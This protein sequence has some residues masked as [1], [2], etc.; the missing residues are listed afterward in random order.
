MSNHPQPKTVTSGFCWGPK[1]SNEHWKKLIHQKFMKHHINY[2]GPHPHLMIGV[3]HYLRLHGRVGALNGLPKANHIVR[4]ASQFRDFLYIPTWT[5]QRVP[6]GSWVSNHHPLGSNWH[7][8]ER[9]GILLPKRMSGWWDNNPWCREVL[10]VGEVLYPQ[11]FGD[12][13]R[14]FEL[15][16]QRP[17]LKTPIFR[18]R[19]C[20]CC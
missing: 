20:C 6:N 5:F 19:C 10:E 13:P 2:P 15:P 18:F 3:L 16:A 11:K 12:I 14:V 8:L 4:D 1:M 9:A 7:P 17:F